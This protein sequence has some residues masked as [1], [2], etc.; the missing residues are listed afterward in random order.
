MTQSKSPFFLIEEFLSPLACED[1]IDRLDHQFPN[2]DE[3]GR[4][5]KTIKFNRLS[6]LRIL[7]ALEVF[8]PEFEE[9][10]GYEHKGVTPFTF[11]WHPEKGVSEPPRCE[12][13]EYINKRWTRVNNH[14]FT[15]IIFLNSHQATVPFDRDY[16]V[17][18]GTLQFPNHGFSIKPARG[19]LVIFPGDQHFINYTSPVE[20][21][22]LNQIRFHIA[23]KKPYVYNRAAFPGD[24]TT[25]F[26]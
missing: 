11:E 19:T 10:Y 2:Y 24:Y 14:D 8:L 9:Y 13:S 17:R 21:G 3:R 6:E 25:W 16:E 5:V 23:S 22:N 20:V 26:K 1:I 12:N 7:P 4:G 15:G 18:G